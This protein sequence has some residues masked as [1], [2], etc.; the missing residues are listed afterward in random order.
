MGK[1]SVKEINKMIEANWQIRMLYFERQ[2]P[3]F[4]LLIEPDVTIVRSDLPDDTFNFVISARFTEEKA[5]KGIEH[6]VSLFKE[7]KFPVCWWESSSDTP[8]NLDQYLQKAQFSLRN[9]YRT[10]YLD[11]SN[12]RKPSSKPLQNLRIQQVQNKKELKD[13]TEVIIPVFH[14]HRDIYPL[15][16]EKIPQALYREGA[17]YEIYVGYW[18]DKPV[19]SA[20]FFEDAGVGGIY[21]LGTLPDARH[22]GIATE[23]VKHLIERAQ[24]KELELVAL[25]ANAES[26]SIMQKLGFLECGYLREFLLKF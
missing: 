11:L 21:Y 16:Y 22:H 24:S 19:A 6:V 15:F 2:L 13:F 23:M 7:K 14:E 1:A 12:Y 5:K 25:H 17:P 3:F 18:D 9:E 20:T 10:C 8:S 4:E 26:F